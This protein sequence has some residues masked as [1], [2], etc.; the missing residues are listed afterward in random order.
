[1]IDN[2]RLWSALAEA[3]RRSDWNDCLVTARMLADQ[4]P[5]HDGLRFLLAALYLRVENHALAVFQYEKLLSSAVGRRDLFRAIAAQRQID[6]LAAGRPVHPRRFAAMLQWFRSVAPRVERAPHGRLR[7]TPGRLLRLAPDDFAYIS[8]SAE[9]QELGIESSE[10]RDPERCV[11]LFGRVRCTLP[12]VSP[13]VEW[14]VEEGD[15]MVTPKLEWTPLR[16]L[17]FPERPSSLLRFGAELDECL[18]QSGA[19]ADDAPAE[20]ETERV[21]S[22]EHVSALD[23]AKP[24]ATAPPRRDPVA[25][26][27]KREAPAAAA[28]PAAPEPAPEPVEIEESEDAEDTPPATK[29]EAAGDS[30]PPVRLALSLAD[31][32]VIVRPSTGDDHLVRGRAVQVSAERVMLQVHPPRSWRWWRT[33]R[34]RE[35]ELAIELGEGD[36]PVTVAARLDDADEA[37]RRKTSRR[38]GTLWLPLELQGLLGLDRA[39]FQDALLAERHRNGDSESGDSRRS[40]AA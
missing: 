32:S 25:P 4:K 30:P 11:L 6:V 10:L 9:I 38:R 26:P 28:P 24:A 3:W 18:S 33:I 40:K 36:T 20:P 1:V 2:P 21:L 16:I 37:A 23:E 15:A 7:L 39:R 8:Q 14:T 35:F 12:D 22:V 27:A 13:T 34:E 17:V 29:H 19:S 5:D 31:R